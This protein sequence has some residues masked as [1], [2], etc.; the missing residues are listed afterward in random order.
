MQKNELLDIF[1]RFGKIVD[2]HLKDDFAF[3]E[4]KYIDNAENAY[5]QLN[6]TYIKGKKIYIEEARP[7]KSRNKQS[8]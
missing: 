6:H 2:Y 1:E 3:L 5:H 4:Y 8:D 7:E